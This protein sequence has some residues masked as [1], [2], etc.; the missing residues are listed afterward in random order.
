MFKDRVAFMNHVSR[1]SDTKK[2]KINVSET[3]RVLSIALDTLGNL[4]VSDLAKVLYKKSA[5]KE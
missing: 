5:S 3:K 4:T 2:Q 1:L